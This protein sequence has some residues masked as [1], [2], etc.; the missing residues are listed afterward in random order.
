MKL[1]TGKSVAIPIEFVD[2]GETENIYFNPADP[3]LVIR[4]DEME[5][6]VTEQLEG[7]KDFELNAD[8]TPKDRSS[9]ELFQQTRQIICDEI[10]RAFNGEVSSVIFKYCNP[11]ALVNGNYFVL[12]FLEAITPE[13]EKHIKKERAK[14]DKHLAKYQK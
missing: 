9:V 5:K 6:R 8:G 10:D 12:Q 13:M 1:N 3:D 7:L 2:R 11:F 14:V 4:F